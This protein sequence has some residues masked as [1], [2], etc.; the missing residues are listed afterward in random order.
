MR[1]AFIGLSGPI[2]YD[3]KN[4][5][6]RPNPKDSD[7]PNAILED[8]FG[9]MLLYD[10]LIFVAPQLCPANMRELPY[11]RFLSEDP[12]ALQRIE[13]A[14]DQFR[15]IL[16]S[17]GEE[18]RAGE[19]LPS[20]QFLSEAQTAFWNS[21]NATMNRITGLNL[22]GGLSQESDPRFVVDNH[23][24]GFFAGESTALHGNAAD[25][26]NILLDWWLSI[27]TE[28]DAEIVYNGPA[29]HY[30][31]SLTVASG[32][33]PAAACHPTSLTATDILI[34]RHLPSYIS[35]LGPYHESI[36][37]LRNHPKIASYRANLPHLI[38]NKADLD[39]AVTGIEDLAEKHRDEVFD[40]Y[41]NEYRS[42]RTYGKIF[43]KAL[44]ELKFPGYGLIADLREQ[45]KRAQ[46]DRKMGWTGFV[47]DVPK[48]TGKR[49]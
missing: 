46:E 36:E 42:Y 19:D 30:Y 12:V 20:E 7:A 18:Y 39:H 29:S 32:F 43:L 47:L 13:T 48:I 14:I 21:W 27:A 22:G 40:K 26:D 45:F 15:S 33:G 49:S 3:Y 9:L 28:I 16:A 5:T 2:G 31:N 38:D 41:M 37:D 23:S 4:Q 6:D 11:V 25:L 24:H 35:V 44:A 1:R 8:G 17:R 34:A 10:E